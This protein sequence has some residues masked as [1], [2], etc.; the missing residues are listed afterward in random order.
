MKIM[1]VFLLVHAAL[2]IY[3]FPTLMNPTLAESY[4]RVNGGVNTQNSWSALPTA[5]PTHFTPSNNDG[6]FRSMYN[7]NSLAPYN[8]DR[9]TGYDSMS[10]RFAP[11]GQSNNDYYITPGSINADYG[12][13]QTLMDPNTPMYRNFYDRYF[14]FYHKNLDMIQAK[15][16]IRKSLMDPTNGSGQTT[17]S[18]AKSYNWKD[19]WFTDKEDGDAYIGP[20]L[21]D[22]KISR[23]YSSSPRS[24]RQVKRQASEVRNLRGKVEDLKLAISVIE[25]LRAEQGG[26]GVGSQRR[27]KRVE[28]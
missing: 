13:P 6:A 22:M 20:N 18:A 23:T 11:P 8:G 5:G 10:Q 28:I 9:F 3:D 7:V 19:N 4:S 24:L 17:I 2:C 21:P 26:Q 14:D 16:Q 25:K 27:S 12:A 15:M 1:R